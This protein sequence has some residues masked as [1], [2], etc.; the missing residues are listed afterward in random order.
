MANPPTAGDLF[1]ENYC[2]ANRS[3]LRWQPPSG[4]RAAA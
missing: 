1:F 3:L 4:V 2:S